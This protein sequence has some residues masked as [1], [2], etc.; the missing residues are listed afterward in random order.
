V[1]KREASD[2]E[3]P[4]AEPAAGKAAQP[5]VNG[6]ASPQVHCPY[7]QASLIQ[8]ALTPAKM[9]IGFFLGAG[10]PSAVRLP[11]GEHTKALIPDIS[12]LTKLVAAKIETL[13]AHKEA[14][15]VVMKRLSVGGVAHPNVEQILTHVR[16]LSD[17]ALGGTIDG[18]SRSTLTA[19]DDEICRI[20]TE[21]VQALLPG[22]DTAYHHLATWIGGIQR[23]HPV[24]IFTPNYDLL[25]EQALEQR[26]VP[27]FDGFVGSD[28]TFFDIGSMELDNLPARWSRLWKVH[29]SINWWRTPVGKVERRRESSSGDRQMIHPTHLKYEQSRRLPY[30][31]MLDRFKAFL[32]RGQSVLVTCGYSFSDQHLNEVI[33]QGLSA[34]PDAVCFGLLHRD[35][36]NYPEAVSQARRQANL[37]LLAID[38]AVL[39]TIERD[40]RSDPREDHAL[41][42]LAVAN[43]DMKDRT[44]APKERCKFLLGD[45]KALGVFLARQLGHGEKKE[46]DD[47]K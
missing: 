24:E 4:G 27:Y 23:T 35:R 22:D 45:F 26:H 20:T 46:E 31:A 30:F 28:R 39:N 19:L 1:A 6:A 16:S 12:G 33:V 7:R 40:W 2:P 42:D 15:S 36:G 32:T 44:N 3:S 17:V 11:D 21:V 47:A 10:C 8:Q 38:G 13:E 14:F 41:H 9:R 34:N 29:G 43:V 18:L 25:M 5:R 37:R